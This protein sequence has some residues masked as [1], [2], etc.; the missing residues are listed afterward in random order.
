[1]SDDAHDCRSYAEAAAEIGIGARQVRALALTQH[2]VRCPWPGHTRRITTTSVESEKAWRSRAPRWRR[3][4]RPFAVAAHVVV[5]VITE[6][7]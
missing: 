3:A 1:M 2:L 6:S 4:L 5:A 7:L